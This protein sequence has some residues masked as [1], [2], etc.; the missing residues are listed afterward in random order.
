M[1]NYETLLSSYADKLTLMQW[2]KKVEA[3]LAGAA[4]ASVS[5]EQPTETTAVLTFHFADGTALS[6]PSLI[7]PKGEKGESVKSAYIKDG[8]LHLVLTD[9]DDLDAGNMYS[10]DI[11]LSG[12]LSAAG[13]TALGNIYAAGVTAA[14]VKTPMLTSDEPEISTEKP[15][16]EVMNGYSFER[17]YEG[18][19]Y[20]INIT[21]AGAVKNGNKLTL[22]L[23][24][25]IK[26]K[27]DDIDVGIP[28][29]GK[30]A[31]PSSLFDKLLT[32]ANRLLDVKRVI[33]I[34][35]YTDFASPI[36]LV[37][38]SRKV[39]GKVEILLTSVKQIPLDTTYYSRYEA[40]FLLSDNMA[41]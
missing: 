29:V 15:V 24:F 16:V 20:D 33:L 21:Y 3:A 28:I 25:S 2:L 40:T 30:F 9:G 39:E 1:L 35:R 8:N 12:N 38:F 7:L 11:A 22:S 17:G 27:S 37:M 13:V 32:D 31:I 10:G 19:A 41:A 34:S 23:A 14:N 26:R 18:P 6:S 4:L 5:I 36:S